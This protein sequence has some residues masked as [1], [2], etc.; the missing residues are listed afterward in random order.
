MASPP[1]NPDTS[2]PADNAIV[3][4]FP[5]NERT[6]R[7]NLS[8]WLQVDHNTS[9][10]H[11]QMT[12]VQGAEPAAPGAGLSVLWVDTDGILHVKSGASG[13]DEILGNPP[14]TLVPYTGATTA[15]NGY[16]LPAG[17]AVSRT[18]YSRL[19]AKYSALSYPFGAGDGST[20][21]GLPDLR[22]RHPIAL[23]NLNGSAANR[24][25]VGVAGFSGTTMGAAGGDQNYQQ[26]MHNYTD[27]THVHAQQGTFTSSGQSADHTHQ[28]TTVSIGGG[29]QLQG[30]SPGQLSGTPT[31]GASNDHTHNVT[32]SGNVSAA[33]VGITISNSGTGISGN[34]QP[35]IVTAY[36]LKW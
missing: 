35:S 28:E 29:T 32:I 13:T 26:H 18:T 7:D 4:Q 12:V 15:P 20:T 25:T 30:G 14:G 17:Q 11:K 21:F 1:F 10:Q 16:L 34:V 6:L 36:I 5:A 9:G 33:G 2:N 22:G 27:P 31:S 19:N 3:S 24:I 8:S 23:D